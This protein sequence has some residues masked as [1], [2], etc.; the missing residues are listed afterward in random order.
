M[1]TKKKRKPQLNRQSE[2][3]S[4]AHEEGEQGDPPRQRLPGDRRRE[5]A[6]AHSLLRQ[7]DTP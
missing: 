7:Q 3:P 4:R 2:K 5:L 1:D 6:Q